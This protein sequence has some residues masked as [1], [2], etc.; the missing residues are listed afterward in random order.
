[1]PESE[2]GRYFKPFPGIRTNVFL[3]APVQGTRTWIYRADEM[4]EFVLNFH[5]LS[6]MVDGWHVVE[7]SP[8]IVAE[9]GP[10][11]L[12]VSASRRGDDTLI[13]YEISNPA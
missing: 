3:P 8:A 13:V 11:S 2:L 9:R 7:F 6:L 10:S 5:R 12:S 1:M 4:P